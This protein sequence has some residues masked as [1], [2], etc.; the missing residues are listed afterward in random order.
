M[1]GSL[2]LFCTGGS[3]DGALF[4]TGGTLVLIMMVVLMAKENCV[5][6]LLQVLI[7]VWQ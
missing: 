1:L 6:L 4:G 7:L 5:F 3:G 2:L